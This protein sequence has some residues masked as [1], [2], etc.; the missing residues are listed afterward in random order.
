MP[1]RRA[2]Q[3]TPVFLLGESPWTEEPGRLP[4]TESQRAGHHWSNWAHTDR[5]YL[6]FVSYLHY[7]HCSR[8]LQA[9][10]VFS[11]HVSLASTRTVSRV[12]LCLAWQWP[13]WREHVTYFG[14]YPLIWICLMLCVKLCIPFQIIEIQLE[15]FWQKCHQSNVGSWCITLEHT[16]CRFVPLV[17]MITSLRALSGGKLLLS[18][19]VSCEDILWDCVNI[20][21]LLKLLLGL[22]STNDFLSESI[23]IMVAKW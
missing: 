6:D 9:V 19:R 17:V 10:I 13:F 7:V 21:L 1:W 23:V 8:R 20:L 18:F 11:C 2:W 22:A 12:L 3:P 4:S 14:R 15:Y 5:P 16:W